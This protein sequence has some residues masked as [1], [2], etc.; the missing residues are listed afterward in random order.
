MVEPMAQ[1]YLRGEERKRYANSLRARYEKD[2]V[3]VRDLARE[4]GYSYGAVHQMLTDVGTRFR[5]QGFPFRQGRPDG[6]TSRF[7]RRV[8]DRAAR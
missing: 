7:S 5:E 2:G 6:R 8:A 1:K 4:S 3:S